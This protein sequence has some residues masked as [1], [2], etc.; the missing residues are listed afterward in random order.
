MLVITRKINEAIVINQEIIITP[1]SI[2]GQSIRLGIKAPRH[3]QVFRHELFKEVGR[4]NKKALQSS[5][6]DFNSPHS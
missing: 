4:E 1:L 2:K 5:K 6:G 3:I